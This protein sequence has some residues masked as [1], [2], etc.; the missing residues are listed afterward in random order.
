M[1]EI[2]KQNILIKVG[3]PIHS[4]ILTNYII[5]YYVITRMIFACKRKNEQVA[6]K[7]KTQ[8]NLKK[9]SKLV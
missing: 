2:N 8:K 5:T 1:E 7:K 3:C 4:Q 9:I 6:E